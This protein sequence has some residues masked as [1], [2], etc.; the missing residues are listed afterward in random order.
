M[1]AS[2]NVNASLQGRT[3]ANYRDVRKVPAT[4]AVA[5]ESSGEYHPL[6]NATPIGTL[7]A[8]A[9]SESRASSTNVVNRTDAMRAAL[10][11]KRASLYSL[12]AFAGEIT[13]PNLQ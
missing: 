13:L 6:T 5:T 7:V 3:R 11:Q 8:L 1:Q 4:R 9:G 10:E 12:R 2:K